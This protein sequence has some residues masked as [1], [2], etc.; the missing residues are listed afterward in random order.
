MNT[1]EVSL[2]GSR[3]DGKTAAREE[4]A[5]HVNNRGE[6]WLV[7]Q[8][9]AAQCVATAT[10]RLTESFEHAPLLVHFADGSHL[11]LADAPAAH[12]AL[13]RAG[14][15][16]APHNGMVAA[17]A[18]DWRAAVLALVFL[19]AAVAAFYVW[20]L[21]GLAQVAVPLVP[22]VWKTAIGDAAMRQLDTTLFTP[23]TL[24]ESQRAEIQQRF[25]ELAAGERVKYSLHFRHF[26]KGP[27]AV[28][29]PGNHVILTDELVAF[30]Q[31]D[32]GVITGVLA[33]ELGHI[34][35]EH[36][37]R[38]VIQASALSMLGSALI[39]DYSSILATLP[40]VLGQLH[41]SREFEAEADTYSHGLLCALDFDPAKT[42]DF[43]DQVQKIQDAAGKLVPSYL[44]SHPD[45]VKRATF[46]RSKC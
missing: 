9:S 36:G 4:V 21:P 34:K 30:V 33:H 26:S 39:G 25:D 46:F 6:L 17:L 27:N 14:V 11:E 5:L 20:L 12:A 24:P 3:F 2:N 32:V 29:L 44:Q 43:F 7:R 35:H 45:S 22:S 41:Y 23:S 13:L 16:P 15:P 18:R 1:G 19:V 38:M 8:G 31:G 10:M 42:A 40:A 37:L 28:A